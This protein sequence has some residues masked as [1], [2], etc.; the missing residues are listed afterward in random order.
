MWA[1]VLVD[2]EIPLVVSMLSL[3]AQ[4]RRRD[5]R[6]QYTHPNFWLLKELKV[7]DEPDILCV[8]ISSLLYRIRPNI[9]LH[10]ISLSILYNLM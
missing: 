6:R 10:W 3:L 2:P 4:L 1:G 7:R 9:R 8:R 5:E